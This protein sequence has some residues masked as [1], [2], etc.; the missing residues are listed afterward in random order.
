[1]R[2]TFPVA[3]CLVAML[4]IA[5]PVHAVI[6]VGQPA[7]AFTKNSLIGSS[8]G[9]ALSLSDYGRQVKILFVLGYD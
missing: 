2:S 9:P 3:L 6:G 8:S 7:N 1:M 4:A 5:P